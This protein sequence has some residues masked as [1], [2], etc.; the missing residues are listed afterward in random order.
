MASDVPK[1]TKFYSLLLLLLSEDDAEY[2]SFFM[3]VL[4]IS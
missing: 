3:E 4:V 1:M 2:E